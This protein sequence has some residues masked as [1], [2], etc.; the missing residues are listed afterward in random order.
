MSSRILRRPNSKELVL[1]DV[2][3]CLGDILARLFGGSAEGTCHADA[4]DSCNPVVTS[5]QVF[6]RSFDSLA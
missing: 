6:P 1:G 2:V 4:L 3:A 5:A